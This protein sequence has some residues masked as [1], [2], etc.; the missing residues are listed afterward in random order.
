M[1][2]AVV[3]M[4][5]VVVVVVAAAAATVPHWIWSVFGHQLEQSSGR[6][7]QNS[8]DPRGFSHRCH[9]VSPLGMQPS[10][11]RA[12][13]AGAGPQPPS[14]ATLLQTRPGASGE[15]TRGQ[16]AA[17]DSNHPKGDA[18]CKCSRSEWLL[19]TLDGQP[20]Y[21]GRSY[22]GSIHIP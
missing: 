3:V 15:E 16:K 21:E 8:P 1:A 9:Q 11:G 6:Y 14:T 12:Q 2:A 5:V 18:W 19:V 7:F 17:A 4:V 10:A 22:R 13:L 20:A